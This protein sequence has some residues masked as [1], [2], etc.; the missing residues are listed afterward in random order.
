MHEESIYGLSAHWYYK[1]KRGGSG[2]QSPAWVKEIVD[3]QK[4]ISNTSELVQNIK[5]DV[6]RDR[7]FV[8]FT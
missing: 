3:I 4:E 1:S 6:F 5:M 2:Y 8:F 7:I